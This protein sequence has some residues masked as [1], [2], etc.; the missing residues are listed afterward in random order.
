MVTVSKAT[1]IV[2]SYDDLPPEGSDHTRPLYISI[3]CSSRRVP[4]VLL[5]NGSALNVCSLAIVIA[6]DY[7]PSDFG[8]STQIIRAY[9]STRREVM[10]TLEIELLIGPAIFVTLFHV[11]RIPRSFN[12][13]LG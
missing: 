9:D 10:G 8:P 5:D 2:F 4:F 3:S 7:A 6:L 12:L 11:L 1:C 13:L